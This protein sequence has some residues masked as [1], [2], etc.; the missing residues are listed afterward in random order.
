MTS[1]QVTQAGAEQSGR[2]VPADPNVLVLVGAAGDLTKRLLMPALYNLA[3]DGLLP[4][5]F[6]IIAVARADMSQD[7]LREKFTQDIKQFSTRKTFDENVW[8]DLVG[9]L[10]YCKGD[11]DKAE[12]YNQLKSQVSQLDGQY[13]ANGNVLYYM[14]VAPSVFGPISK[15]LSQ[16]GLNKPSRGWA[17]VIVEKPFGHD[18]SSAIALN[19]ELLA[20]WTED[21]IYRIDHYLGKE[22][23]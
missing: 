16:A 23:V 10:Y 6:A 15:G 14:A 9:R 17:R 20:D 13:K 4:K 18:L 11:F 5:Q 22:T 12:T 21:Q 1:E 8:K 2:A 19:R 7:Q 3:C